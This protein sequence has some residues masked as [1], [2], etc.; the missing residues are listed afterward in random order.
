[1]F[2]NIISSLI[3]AIPTAFAAFIATSATASTSPAK[4]QNRS[5]KPK[6]PDGF[7][8]ARLPPPPVKKKNA[9]RERRMLGV[10][11]AAPSLKKNLGEIRRAE[12]IPASVDVELKRYRGSEERGRRFHIEGGG[13]DGE[14]GR[15]H[16]E[17]DKDTVLK[18]KKK[19]EMRRMGIDAGRREER[20]TEVKEKRKVELSKKRRI[21]VGRGERHR[22]KDRK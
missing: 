19:R 7:L 2:L 1:M 13:G 14:G 11:R 21:K 17:G 6:R 3:T 20:R 8:A 4:E 15:I 22:A 12:I 18:E 5:Q 10:D 9:S 16:I